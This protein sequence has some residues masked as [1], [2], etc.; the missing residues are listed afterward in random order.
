MK[1]R[2]SGKITIPHTIYA[3]HT[4]EE[5][6]TLLKSLEKDFNVIRVE[7]KPLGRFVELYFNS[8]YKDCNFAT[9]LSLKEIYYSNRIYKE[10][11]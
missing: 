9:V 6:T 3:T 11:S 2:K 4:E 1:F 7:D 8:T 10:A 5:I